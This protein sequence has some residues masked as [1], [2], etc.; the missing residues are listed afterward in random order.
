[1]STSYPQRC[2]VC[3]EYRYLPWCCAAHHNVCRECNDRLSAAVERARQVLPKANSRID[4]AVRL[5]VAGRVRLDSSGRATVIG[6]H[7]T[8]AVGNRCE[9]SHSRFNATD[10]WCSHRIARALVIRAREA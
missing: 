9:C 6:D 7:G 10:A 2:T 8:Y 1:M 4:K 5:V 3:G